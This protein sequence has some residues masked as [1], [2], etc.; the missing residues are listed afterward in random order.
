VEILQFSIAGLREE[1]SITSDFDLREINFPTL[2][3]LTG[4]ISEPAACLALAALSGTPEAF[5]SAPFR[6]RHWIRNIAPPEF[7]SELFNLLNLPPQ[8]I[9][10]SN[11]RIKRGAELF[12]IDVLAFANR[13]ID[14]KMP[15]C[16]DGLDPNAINQ[17]DRQLNCVGCHIPVQRTGQSPATV[18]AHNLT[19]KWAPIFSDL[20]LHKG[21][22]VTT[23][24]AA[25]P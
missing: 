7:G 11:S 2:F 23:F 22:V 10:H 15:A 25:P 12:G 24:G 13:L 14:G 20:L 18:G 21:P 3:P 9:V 16:G 5:L 8:S 1:L 6:E 19:Y 17:A 4:P